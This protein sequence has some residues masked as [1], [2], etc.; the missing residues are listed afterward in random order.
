MLCLADDLQP[1]VGRGATPAIDILRTL[2]P[3]ASMHMAL[4]AIG[5][6][7]PCGLMARFEGRNAVDVEDAIRSA[8]AEFPLLRQRLVWRETGAVSVRD[9]DAE[10]DRRPFTLTYRVGAGGRPWSYEV[11]QNG[12]DVWFRATF[13]HAIAD[14]Y[15]M[16][17]FLARV[18]ALLEGGAY[19]DREFICRSAL[20]P[21]LFQTW[22]AEFLA[23]QCRS[24]LCLDRPGAA[25]GITWV[26]IPAE[27]ASPLLDEARTRFGG[28]GGLLAAAATLAYAEGVA[29]GERKPALIN[30][31]VLRSRLPDLNGFGFG[32]GSLML[33]VSLKPVPDVATLA[34]RISRKA[35]KM[36]DEDWDRNLN[37]LLGRNAAHH[38]RMA[39]M[40]TGRSSTPTLTV[41]WKARPS[42]LG[43]GDGVRDIA[44]F[45]LT[46]G[47][48]VSAHRDGNGLSLSLTD[49]HTRAE[50]SATLALLLGHLGVAPGLSA[51]HYGSRTPPTVSGIA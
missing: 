49:R 40:R 1:V 25:P 38:R 44:C 27:Q 30:L 7:I 22:M 9:D 13:A 21:R 43:I 42:P 5:A 28:F 11:T 32:A 14:G 39:Q 16:L 26:T 23:L 47:A 48:H 18:A 19:Q 24:F 51:H 31:Q 34:V 37:R 12:R 17:H 4:D 45:S 35:R 3:L 2:G 15:S 46:P 6:G 29:P 20:K 41:S 33:P 50:R 10:P 8:E 36:V